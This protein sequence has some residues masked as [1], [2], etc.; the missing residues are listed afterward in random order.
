MHVKTVISGQISVAR[1]KSEGLYESLSLFLVLF[2][3][4]FF[5]AL[6]FFNLGSQSGALL[7]FKQKAKEY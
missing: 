4:K 5:F 2:V 1:R 6:K 3:S 7:N